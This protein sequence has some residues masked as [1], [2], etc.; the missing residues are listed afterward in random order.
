M[1]IVKHK[2][3]AIHYTL[4][5]NEG[6]VLDSSA[7]REPLY[8]IQGIGNLIPG[9]EE[10]LEGKKEGDKLNL[11]ISPEKGYGEKDEKMIQRVPRSAFGGGEI[12]KGMQFQTNQG[13]IV[14]VTEVGLSEVTVDANHPLAGV[15]L[16]FAVEVISIRE[17]TADELAHGHVHGPGG[18][19][20][21]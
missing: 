16:N 19:H 5:D 4:T 11:K 8:Y 10:G 21:H 18:H 9:M 1:Q 15:E 20:H 14:T 2:V 3:A 13:Q 7:G 6:K 12:K 17:A